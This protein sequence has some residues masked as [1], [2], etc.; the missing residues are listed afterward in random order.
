M[1]LGPPRVALDALNELHVLLLQQGLRRS[2]AGVHHTHEERHDPGFQTAPNLDDIGTA[3]VASSIEH[4]VRAPV[5]QGMTP[6]ERLNV[7][8]QMAVVLL[9]AAGVQPREADD[10]QL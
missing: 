9:Q 7:I 5:L 1:E 3:T 4:R 6:S 10:E 8:A 2:C